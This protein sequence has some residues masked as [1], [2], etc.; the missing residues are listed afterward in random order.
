MPQSYFNS[1]HAWEHGDSGAEP[2]WKKIQV[3]SLPSHL[4]KQS[5]PNEFRFHP[6]DF[7]C[8]GNR[9]VTSP[10]G[11]EGATRAAPATL[12]G[13]RRFSFFRAMGKLLL[14]RK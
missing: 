1:R 13:N 8:P 5:R 10:G 14:L 7:G 11:K 12:V 9:G 4:G 3:H 2:P 6:T